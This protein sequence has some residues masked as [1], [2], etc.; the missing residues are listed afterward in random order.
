MNQVLLTGRLTSNPILRVTQ[1]N[2][3]VSNFTLA[4]N[5]KFSDTV[6][7]IDI[8]AWSNIAETTEK[9]LQKG[10]KINVVGKLKQDK[11]QDNEGK[12]KYKNYVL[13]VEID[14]LLD[15]K[16]EEKERILKSIK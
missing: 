10:S 11:Y 4:V 5:D 16:E 9:Y 13:A 1:T 7:F 15:T 12:T 2:T 6:D 8:V 3:K 14:Y